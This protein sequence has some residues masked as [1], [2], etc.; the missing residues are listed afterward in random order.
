MMIEGSGSG[1]IPLTSGSGSGSGRPKNYLIAG[2][3]S[4]QG[5]REG[6]GSEGQHNNCR[7]DSHQQTGTAGG[8]LLH[9][10]EYLLI[11]VYE[12]IQKGSGAKSYI[13][14]SFLTY[15]KMHDYFVIY[16]EV[17]N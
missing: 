2:T 15:E 7:H 3:G 10:L 13:R 17:H 5:T 11:R 12:E 4:K 14:K 8:I 9:S 16:E 6:S 1:S